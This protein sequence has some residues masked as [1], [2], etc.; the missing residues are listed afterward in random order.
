MGGTY[1]NL[2]G[3]PARTITNVVSNGG[4]CRLTVPTGAQGGRRAL[5]TGDKVLVWGV[6]G[7]TGANTSPSAGPATITVINST[8]VDIQGSTFGGAYTSGGKM[9]C[10]I[11]QATGNSQVG[12]NLQDYSVLAPGDCG[13][14]SGGFSGF[15]GLQG[16]QYS[17]LDPGANTYHR[18][19]VHVLLSPCA[20]LNESAVPAI[21]GNAAAHMQIMQ[22]AR[23]SIF[24]SRYVAG[25][26][27]ISFVKQVYYNAILT[28]SG[29]VVYTGPGA[30]GGAS[31]VTG[32]QYI[33]YKGGEFTDGITDST[34]PGNTDGV[35]HNV[36]GPAAAVVA[37]A[38]ARWNGATGNLI[39]SSPVIVDD[40]GNVSGVAGLTAT[41]AVL[42]A[43]NPKFSVYAS[44]DASI[45]DATATKIQMNT[46]EFDI[47]ANFDNATNF[48]HTPQI[49]GKYKYTFQVTWDSPEVGAI[50][51]SYI[52]KNGAAHKAT[53]EQAA[54]TNFKSVKVEAFIN[55]NGTT[56]YVEFFGYQKLT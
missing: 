20:S 7:A 49:A 36:Y 24:Q 53:I 35:D 40:S 21:T 56:D 37:N 48:R 3:D 10:T 38:L 43:G 4:L 47:G 52:H 22:G 12:I 44:A 11:I 14:D 9:V 13:F 30:R 33:K 31:P 18:A 29:A 16:G 54:N 5:Q 26:L 19:S 25:G 8:T 39:K 17:I 50:L 51:F 55:M 23:A 28:A 27:T 41:G 45:N 2:N 34:W 1:P 6:L 15:N 42:A 46:E 32:Q